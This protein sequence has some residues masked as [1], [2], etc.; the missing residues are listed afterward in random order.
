MTLP[1]A[2]HVARYEMPIIRY[3][4]TTLISWIASAAMLE[5]AEIPAG[6]QRATLRGARKADR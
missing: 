1:A 3:A 6:A 5:T 4:V 2:P